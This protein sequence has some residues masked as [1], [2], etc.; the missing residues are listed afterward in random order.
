MNYQEMNSSL[1]RWSCV[2]FSRRK[3][4]V[5]EGLWP[6]NKSLGSILRQTSM[7]RMEFIHLIPCGHMFNVFSLLSIPILNYHKN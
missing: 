4:S 1:V 6:S 7:F 5:N 3:L 2:V